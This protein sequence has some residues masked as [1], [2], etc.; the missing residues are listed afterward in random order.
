MTDRAR[1]NEQIVEAA[2][3]EALARDIYLAVGMREEEAQLTARLQVE[4]DLRGVHSH[5]TRALPGYVAGLESG[6]INVRPKQRTVRSAGAVSVIDGDR[7]LGHAAS[8]AAMLAAVE[9]ARQYGLGATGVVNSRHFGAAACYSMLAAEEGMIG[10]AA[11]NSDCASVPA[12]GASAP[13]TAN[14]AISYAVPASEEQPIVLDMACA[15]AAWGTIRTMTLYDEIIPHG[16][17]LGNSGHPVADLAS[18]AM[19]SPAAG[20]RGFGLALGAGIVAGPLVGGKLACHKN[21]DEDESEHFLL[22]INIAN[23]CD[24]EHFCREIDRGIRTIRGISSLSG[25]SVQ[26]PGEREW[27]R[28]E[29]WEQNGIPIHKWHLDQLAQVATAHD[30]SVPWS[31]SS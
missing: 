28:R 31:S 6:E 14:N 18:A 3:L 27:R 13:A 26:L 2:A 8:V 24:S 5:G 22:A 11:T 4:T 10:F 1:D 12:P 29:Q 16:W 7:G 21:K 17:L 20:P 19:I 9:S 25:E 30:V 15:V 23:F